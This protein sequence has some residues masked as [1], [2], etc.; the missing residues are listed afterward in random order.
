[1]EQLKDYL[2][3]YMKDEL[4]KYTAKDINDWS[5]I[6]GKHCI[7]T[8]CGDQKITH[9]DVDEHLASEEHMNNKMKYFEWVDN[10]VI[11]EY[12]KHIITLEEASN[13]RK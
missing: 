1:M 10:V 8:Y 6:S 12:K 5:C 11:P 3:K 9:L 4:V 2:V 13:A 7:C